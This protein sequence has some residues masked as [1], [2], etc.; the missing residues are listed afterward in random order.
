MNTNFIILFIGLAGGALP[1]WWITSNYYTGVIAQEHEAQQK[2]VIEQQD[3]GRLELLAYAKTI[4]DA[5]AQHDKDSRI[6]SD[7]RHRLD[8]M[9]VTSICG[10]PVPGAAEG[11][12]D[13]HGAA[14]AFSSGVD[15][16][17]AD[18]QSGVGS[19][20]ERCDTLNIDAIR[21]NAR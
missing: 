13:T 9:R 14:W 19:I 20:V 6:N 21:A 7:L 10:N 18:L 17:F 15:A 4:T 5:G 8:G 3:Q 12:T 1:S 16:A 11:G 2:V